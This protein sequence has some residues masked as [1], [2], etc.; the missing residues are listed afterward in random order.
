MSRKR[1]R[2]LRQTQTWWVQCTV[3][4]VLILFVVVRLAVSHNDLNGVTANSP[5]MNEMTM[6]YVNLAP[7]AILD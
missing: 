7:E 4:A 1:R 6:P 3:F 5:A 2:R